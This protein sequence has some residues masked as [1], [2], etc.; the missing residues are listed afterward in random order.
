[1][2]ITIEIE[3]APTRKAAPPYHGADRLLVD[4]ACPLCSATPF[5]CIGKADEQRHEHDITRAPAI[6]LC[7]KKIVGIVVVRF[8]TIFGREEDEAVLHGRCRVY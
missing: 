4:G 5:H 6:A 2:N 8:S 1:M 7:C 3:R